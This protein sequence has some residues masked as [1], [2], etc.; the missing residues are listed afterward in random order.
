MQISIDSYLPESN[1]QHSV[2]NSTLFKGSRDVLESKARLLR[3]KGIGKNQ[4]NQIA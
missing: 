2:L 1:Y 3:A 4:T